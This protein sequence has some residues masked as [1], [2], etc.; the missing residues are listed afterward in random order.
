MSGF[1]WIK[2]LANFV[3]AISLGVGLLSPRWT[4]AQSEDSLVVRWEFESEET[5]RL[6]PVGTV[7]RD[8]PGPR[9][10]LY[11]DFDSNNTAIKLDG[12]GAHLEF[13]DPG[14]QSDFDFSNSDPITLEAWVQAESLRPGEFVYIVGKGRTAANGPTSDNQ[15]WALRIRERNEQACVSFLFATPKRALSSQGDSHWHRWTSKTGF[16]P[17]KVWH[18]LAISYRYGQPDS[19]RC[20]IDGKPVPGDWD[21]GGKTTEQPVVDNDAIWIGS[22]RGG[23]PANS[24]RGNLDSIAIHRRLFDDAQMAQRYKSTDIETPV[25]LAQEV[26][27]TLEVP[28]QRV[29]MTLHEGLPSHS[30]WLNEGESLGQASMQLGLDSMLLDRLPQ[31]FDAWGIRSAW[32]DPVLVR[33]A[34]DVQLPAGPQTLVIRVR[35]QSRLWCNGNL[36]ARG[37]PI[38][39]SPSGEEP[40]S[41]ITLGPFASTRLAEHRQQQIL[42]EFD[43]PADGKVRVVLETVVGGKG[44]RSDPGETS[45]GWIDPEAQELKLVSSGD[46]AGWIPYDDQHIVPELERIENQLQQHD[47]QLR[48]QLASS[49]DAFWDQRH[50]IAR[51]WAADH[52]VEIPPGEFNAQANPIDRFLEEKIKDAIQRDSQ[53]KE[54][55]EPQVQANATMFSQIVQPLIVHKCGRCHIESDKG[56]LSLESIESM[57][58][59][60]DSGQP[61]IVVGEPSQSL[62]LQRILAETAEDRMPPGDQGLSPSEIASIQSWIAQGANW[63][64]ESI[65]PEQFKHSADLDDASFLRKLSYDLVGVPPSESELIEF[66]G[67]HRSDKRTR[68][69]DRLLQ[70]PRTADAAMGYWQDV[71]AENPTL[72]N[73]SLNTTGPFRW[74]LYD[75]FRD[76]KPVDRWVSELVLMRGNAH[77]GGSAGFGLAGDNDAP[78]AAKAQILASAFLGVET[79]CARCHDSPYHRSTQQ[80]LYSLAAMLEQK[81]LTVPKSS[82]VPAAF[83]ESKSREALI[84]VTLDFEHPVQPA[85]PW[86]DLIETLSD[87][88]ESTRE[89]LAL[90]LTAPQNR[91]FAKVFVNRIW[92]RLMGAG[93]VE[94]PADWENARP[95]HPQLLDWLANQLLENSYDS[96]A[97][98]KLIVSSRAYQRQA[99]G[100]NRRDFLP[101]IAEDLE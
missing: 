93:I 22:S 75:A 41:P 37:E 90:Y 57:L 40:M 21:M 31:R 67:D 49:Q 58:S 77:E 13:E 46:S 2:H 4:C 30:R 89:Q 32:V 7:H 68:A 50:A 12:T 78:Q 11:P 88:P 84:R 47:A 8:I 56:G 53:N 55:R 71:L 5:S 83:F 16:T 81:P 6:R 99:T 100:K 14:T 48:R 36:V 98:V 29:L 72:I 15:N 27:P 23:L 97:I 64:D 74:F 70:D 17:G 60:G 3:L 63:A 87:L 9:L 44:F 73:A 39:G 33:L 34:T 59:G 85:W 76:N 62:L 25:K 52:P 20:W 79:Q 61:A 51:Q 69:I 54:Q 35:G 66:L 96:K 1:C 42:G 18:H 43:V 92:R 26:M 24:F 19:I 38:K 91:R 82:R 45:V 65:D 86:P 80:E 101:P 28:R 95:S 10:P 94:P